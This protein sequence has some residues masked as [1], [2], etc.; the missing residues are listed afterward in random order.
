MVTFT[1]TE[2]IQHMSAPFNGSFTIE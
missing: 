2:Y 1:T